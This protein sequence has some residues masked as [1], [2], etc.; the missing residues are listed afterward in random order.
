MCLDIRNASLACFIFLVCSCC[1]CGSNT[2]TAPISPEAQPMA[3][4]SFPAPP[5]L[6]SRPKLVAFGDSFTA[7]YGID[8]WRKNYPSL[9]QHDLDAAGF[10]LQVVNRGRSGDTSTQA[11]AR[12][13]E[14]LSVG[15]VRIFIVALGGNDVFRGI[16]R[17]ETKSSLAEIMKRAKQKRAR[18]LICGYEVIGDS[19][20]ARSVR[21]M[22]VDL[23]RE[24]SVPL[25]PSLLAGV[26]QDPNLL[27]PDCVHP[28]EAGA[29][30]VEQNVWKA[31]QPLL[32]NEPRK[33]R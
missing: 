25:L 1:G 10:D 15:D 7:G 14:A 31:L 32:R 4:P 3:A 24:N 16:D 11:L 27:L 19:D 2:N 23:A 30:V 6:D 8:D 26:Q 21:Q 12:L 22:Y 29:K 17:D 18:V 9:L 5:P 28:N 13:G 33:G 20:E